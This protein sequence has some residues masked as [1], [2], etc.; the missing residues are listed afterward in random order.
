MKAQKN[1]ALDCVNGLEKQNLLSSPERISCEGNRC[2]KPP[3]PRQASQRPGY[4][5]AAVP[6]GG[7]PHGS[8]RLGC[9]VTLRSLSQRLHTS[10]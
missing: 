6:C 3:Q 4:A 7:L 8:S 5:I 1:L 10:P 9:F 2:A